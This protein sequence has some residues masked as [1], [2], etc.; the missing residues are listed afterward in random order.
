[1]QK[2]IQHNKDERIQFFRK[3]YLSRYLKGFERVTKGII[4]ERWVGDWT[5]LQHIDPQLF[6]LQQHVFPVLLGCSTGGLGAQPQLGYCSH[7]SIFS[8]PDLNFLSP[9]LYNL[10]PPTSCE[11][12]ICTQFNPSTVKVIFWYLQP[13]A[14]A[15][16]TGAFLI[17]QHGRVGGQ[18]ATLTSDPLERSNVLFTYK[19]TLD[20]NISYVN[21][22]ETRSLESKAQCAFSFPM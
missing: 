1:M 14:P 19:F 17:W 8:P 11:R 18:Y 16:Y 13:D 4:C 9:G 5:E 15:I 21:I 12:H 22:L 6:W 10:A 20:N 7:S 3:I 2:L